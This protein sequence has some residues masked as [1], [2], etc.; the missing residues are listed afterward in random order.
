MKDYMKKNSNMVFCFLLMLCLH[1]CKKESPLPADELLS[2][3]TGTRTEFTLD[4]IYLYARQMYLWRDAIPSYNSFDPRKYTTINPAITAFKTALFNLSQLKLDAA[5]G[6]PFEFTTVNNTAKYSYLESGNSKG[7]LAATGTSNQEAVLKT[8]LIT[9]EGKQIAYIAMGSF[10]SLTNS[11]KALDNAFAIVAAV[12]PHYLII[13]LRSNGG[14]YVETAEYVANLVASTA[15]NGKVMYTEQYTTLLQTGKA[16]ILKNQPY[17]DNE[18][19]TVLY[20]GRMA[21]MADVDFTESGNT[22][23]FSKKGSMESI[24]DIY[25]IISSQTAS[26]SELLISALKPYLNVQLV[27]EKTYGKPVGFFPVNIDT[28]SVYI[29]SFVLLNSQGWS[30]YYNGITPDISLSMP[31]N[32]VLGD[33]EEVCLKAALIAIKTNS[34]TG[35]TTDPGATNNAAAP[36]SRAATSNL[37]TSSTS[38]LCA[39]RTPQL[40]G[41]IETRHHLKKQD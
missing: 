9:T 18:G 7:T 16:T 32:P 4:S 6:L 8:S 36:N 23:L 15:L 29:P 38:T 22:H 31:D 26:A 34:T 19:K 33:P 10:P 13:D 17:Y 40:P 2:P 1:S 12:S 30:D 21:T 14:G 24:T 37:K 25:F 27:G 20:N 5:T 41:M 28:Y 11:K 35:S 39:I 3:T